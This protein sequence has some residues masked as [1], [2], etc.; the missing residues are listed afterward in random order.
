MSSP[1]PRRSGRSRAE[2]TPQQPTAGPSTPTR[3]LRKT[4][5]S[6]GQA[7]SARP[8]RIVDTH[9][10]S[11]SGNGPALGSSPI[12]QSGQARRV[13]PARIRRAAG[14]G[15]EG[16]RD[17]EEMIV[18][19]LERYGACL[20]ASGFIHRISLYCHTSSFCR[21]QWEDADKQVYRQILLQIPSLSTSL[22]CPSR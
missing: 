4:P 12:V 6:N 15:Q 20:S 18:D 5:V 3:S 13:L 14:G 8:S 22:L 21:G 10:S 17:L 19:W 2:T 11:S 7:S 9:D 16:I 1:A